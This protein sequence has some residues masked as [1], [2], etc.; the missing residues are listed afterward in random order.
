MFKKLA[1]LSGMGLLALA[2]CG[3]TT[4]TF[5][6]NSVAVPGNDDDAATQDFDGDGDADNVLPGIATLL[7]GAG[8]DIAGILN[9]AIADGTVLI[10][11]DVTSKK[12]EN[13]DKVTVEGYLANT[14]DGGVPA[15]D[16]AD[17]LVVGGNGDV[18][19]FDGAE[20][21]AGN[22]L[23]QQSDFLFIFPFNEATT[24][25]LPLQRAQLTADVSGDAIDQ[26]A[27]SGVV[28]AIDFANVLATL[29]LIIGDVFTNASAAFSGAD[30]V[31]CDGAAN[32]TSAA[33]DAVAAGGLCTDNNADGNADGLCVLADDPT[34]AILDPILGLDFDDDGDGVAERTDNDGV[35]SIVFDAGT[36]SF[37]TNEMDEL[38][39]MTNGVAD[40]L[41]A[42]VAFQLDLDGDG[43]NES[44]P[45][46]L[47]FNAVA[48]V[49]ADSAQ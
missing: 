48:G 41:L 33:C 42:D 27:L 4:K 36:N 31:A 34:L 47:R 10:G 21:I 5:V 38:F 15:F 26:G 49:R 35:I 7:T 2:G 37:T 25:E 24:L 30:P 8:I 18:F 44:M 32:R 14:A 43:N 22:L 16:G 11:I 3:E 45:L 17:E 13:S 40:G 39:S 1:A 6:S 20:I 29:P 23:T 12:F 46:A 28:D 19:A 9:G